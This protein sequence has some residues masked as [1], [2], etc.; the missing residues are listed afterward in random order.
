MVAPR[1]GT[2]GRCLCP[3]KCLL[4]CHVPA[5]VACLFECVGL[6]VILLI[7]HLRCRN[8]KGYDNAKRF[9]SKFTHVSPV[10]YELKR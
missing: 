10:W 2:A 3:W 8:P 6:E 4:Q 5:F 7:V 1:H 9:R